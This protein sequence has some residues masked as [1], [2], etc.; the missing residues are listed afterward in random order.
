MVYAQYVVQDL[1]E[2]LLLYVRYVC[3]P[4]PLCVPAESARQP[5]SRSCEIFRK[6][7]TNHR[8]PTL[9]E[10]RL[11]VAPGGEEV[12]IRTIRVH[13]FDYIL[14]EQGGKLFQAN[15]R[16]V[17][18]TKRR[19]GFNNIYVLN[20]AIYDDDHGEYIKWGTRFSWPG[21]THYR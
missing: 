7:T 19:I 2:V 4:R 9:V 3:T 8:S 11:A 13:S 12:M 20:R 1:Y 17:K 10:S 15:D 6:G 16:M 21:T 18:F 14:L 5:E